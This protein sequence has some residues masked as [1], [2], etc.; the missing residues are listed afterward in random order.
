M[1]AGD[2]AKR[3]LKRGLKGAVSAAGAWAHSRGVRILTYHSVGYRYHDMNVTPEAFRLQMAWLGEHC[4]VVPLEAVLA[5][6]GGVAL[7]FDDGYLDNLR[8]AAPVLAEWQIPATIFLIA[9]RMGETLR[10]EDDPNEERL[11][12]WDEAGTLAAQGVALG[13]HTLTHRRLASLD[14]EEQRREIVESKETIE[15]RLGHQASA[16]AYPF[17]SL[18]D[19]NETSVRLVREAG[20]RLAVSNRFG[21]NGRTRDPWALRRIWI[22]A[23]DDLASFQA[24]LEGKMDALAWLDSPAGI[25]ARRYLNRALRV[26]QD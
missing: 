12:T 16:F 23:T 14:E 11:M 21:V 15:S 6:S 9:D 3:M 1:A 18:L 13:S 10:P 22:D 26:R 5:E 20:Y 24:K 7:T 8:Y 4:R 2:S 25:R 19:Y 17:G